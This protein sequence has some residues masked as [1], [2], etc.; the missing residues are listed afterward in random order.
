MRAREF[1]IEGGWATTVTQGT[2]ITPAVVKQ[3]LSIIQQFTQDFNVW[4]ADKGLPQVQ[5][6]RPTGSSAYH[7]VDPED[8]VY[9]D[10]DL[11]MIAPE[12]E[13]NQSQSQFSGYWNK[14]ADE[15]VKH[16]NLSYV[17][18]T[19]SKIGHPIIEV[20]KDKYVQIDF[21]WHPPKLADWGAARVTPERGVKG[22]L[23]GNM[24]SA[25]GEILDMSIQHAGVQLKVVDNQRVPFSKR[26]DT[27]T[28]TISSSPDTF[29][30]DILKWI[31]ERQGIT[32]PVV[33]KEL[34]ANPGTNIKD[35]KIASLVKGVRGFAQSAEANNMFGKG[36]LANF[37][38]AQDFLGKFIQQY[39]SKAEADIAGAKRDKAATPDAIAR[40]NADREKVQK[41]LAMVM[42]L[43]AGK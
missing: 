12:V 40:A 41:G 5:V 20:A 3:A 16:R 1:I 30:L 8:K 24:F 22:L 4:L 21:M 19:E 6:G 9:G 13:S 31:A 39:R 2:V 14:L 11:Q 28:L 36:D 15:F 7:D 42:D 27:Q 34:A 23:H 25:L 33:S 35:V 26:K 43:F 29:I 37:V 32:K 18:P 17:H 38:N 10:I